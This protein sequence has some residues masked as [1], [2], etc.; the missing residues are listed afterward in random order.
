MEAQK[1]ILDETTRKSLLGYV[2]F[3][4]DS[5]FDFTP[6]EYEA[7]PDVSIRPVFSLRSMTQAEKN[8]LKGNYAATPSEPTI[9]DSE[10]LSEK[11]QTVFI[12]CVAGW[13][14]FFDPGTGMEIIFPSGRDELFENLPQWAVISL[15]EEIRRLSCLTSAEE[16]SIK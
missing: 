11:N 6:K 7:I 4:V 3:S 16:L 5:R 9:A 2:P 1:R 13:K 14:N 15:I 10:A 8:Q 12:G